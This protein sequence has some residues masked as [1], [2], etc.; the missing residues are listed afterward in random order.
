MLE[1]GPNLKEVLEAIV[2]CLVFI[3]YFYFLFG[4]MNR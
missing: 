1:I 4:A 2:P 3:A